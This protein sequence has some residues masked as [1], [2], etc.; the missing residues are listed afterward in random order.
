MQGG[1]NWILR[2]EMTGNRFFWDSHWLESWSNHFC[3]SMGPN[4]G[5][6]ALDSEGV[7]KATTEDQLWL[8][9]CTVQR[10]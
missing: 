9:T 1:K 4:G 3:P 2:K 8:A 6:V 10:T 5:S 7:V